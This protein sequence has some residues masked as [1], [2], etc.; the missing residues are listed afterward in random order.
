MKKK[1]IIAFCLL[2]WAVFSLHAQQNL[3]TVKGLI[4]DSSSKETL[5]G[6]SVVIKNTRQG[7]TTNIDGQFQLTNVASDAVLEISY[8]GYGTKEIPVGG[9]AEL[10]ILLDPDENALDEVVITGYGRIDKRLFTGAT[11]RLVADDVKING[12]AEISRSLEGRSAGVSVQNVSGTFGTRPKI[13]V[14][15]ATSIYGSSNP[16]WVVDGVIVED[17]KD[18]DADALSSGDAETLISSAIAGLNASDIESFQILKDGSATSIYGAKAMAGVIVVTTKRG[19]TGSSSINYTGEFTSRLI[20]DYS[21]FNIMNSQ[22]QMGVY[23]EMQSKGWLNLSE[24]YRKSASGVY[25]KLSQLMH[26]YDPATRAYLISNED[27]AINAYLREAEYRNTDWFREL[28]N[29]NIMQNHALNISGGTEKSTFYGSVSALL[30]P[31]LTVAGSLQRFTGT[32]NLT[33][34]IYKNLT[35]NLNTKAYYRKQQAPGTSKRTID[36]VEGKVNRDFDINP[37]SYALNTSRVLDP[38]EFYTRYYSPF[39]ILHELENNYIDLN[40]TSVNFIAE[41]AYEPLKGLEIKALGNIKYTGTSMEHIIKE[42]SNQAM[43]FRAMDDAYIQAANR[44]LYNN[45]DDPLYPYNR[46]VSVLPVGGILDRDDNRMYGW[47]FRASANYATAFNDGMHLVN[48][49][50]G[51]EVNSVDKNAVWNR[52]WGLQYSKGKI[53]NYDY[54]AFKKWMEDNSVYYSNADTRRRE[55]AFFAMANYSYFG[56]YTINGTARYEGS[57]QMGRSRRARWLPTW[58]VSGAWNAHE[59]GFFKSL[60]PALSHATLRTSYSL[61]AQA[62]PLSVSN[63]AMVIRSRVPWRYYADDKVA[64]LYISQMENSELTYEKKYELNIGGDF[65][66]LNNRINLS[67]DWYKRKNFDLI[68]DIAVQGMGGQSEKRANVAEMESQGAEFTLAT[69][70]IK[71][72]EFGWNSDFTFSKTNV[73]ITK[74]KSSVRIIDLVTGNGFGLEGYSF[75]TLFSIPFA[76]LN[77]KGFPTFYNAAGERVYY[78]NMQDRD[79]ETQKFLIVEGPKEPT[80]QGG[81]GNTFSFRNFKLNV[82]VTYSGGNKLRLDPMFDDTYT[83]LTAMPKEFANRWILSGDEA[84][85]NIPTIVSNRQTSFGPDRSDL[86]IAYNIYNYSTARVADGGFIRLKEI[87]LMYDFPEKLLSAAKF[88]KLALKLQATNLFLLYAD[89]KLNGQ[90]PEFMNSGGV[91]TPVPKQF[92]LTIMLGL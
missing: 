47:D 56:R 9:K 1:R 65:G 34:H 17:V 11:D 15:G 45:P 30:D 77:E 78:I 75:R 50:G 52:D 46:N 8:L 40:E 53:S 16:L 69:K 55:T 81:F 85:T 74:L 35:L 54:L 60:E 28:Y 24:M 7:T 63:A 18:V 64:E 25:G 57:N 48:L 80:F 72:K 66:F 76:G 67:W 4:Y 20:P 87:S 62:P 13:R 23:Q 51:M 10:I 83:D 21:E 41:L 59:E 89:K 88:K 92:T 84:Y 42:S 5:I 73:K 68:G 70:N 33:H 19:K 32:M 27:V 49:F 31:G 2:L 39:N 44:F 61:T 91:A 90:D 12:L 29:T 82:F 22:E 36:A 43:A 37:Y 6:A 38:N 3:P 71:T 86:N 58:N 26:T 79:S 14:R